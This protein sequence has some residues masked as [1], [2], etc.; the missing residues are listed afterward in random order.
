MHKQTPVTALMQQGWIIAALVIGLSGNLL[1]QPAEGVGVNLA[2][3]FGILGVASLS[4]LRQAGRALRSEA[5]GWIVGAVLLTTSAF[6]FRDAPTLHILAFL[7]AGAA[8]SFATRRGGNNWLREGGVIAPLE[9]IAGTVFHTARGPLPRC[10]GPLFRG[11]VIAVPILLLFGALLTEADPIFAA[12]L[13]KILETLVPA[14]LIDHLLLTAVLTW[15]AAGYLTGLVRGTAFLERLPPWARRLN[16]GAV[17]VN[18]VLGLVSVLFVGFLVVQTQTL[19]GG[20]EFVQKTPGLTY[21]IYAREGFFQLVVATALI[22]PLLTVGTWLVHGPSN[23]TSPQAPRPGQVRLFRHLASLHVVLLLLMAAS[24]MARVRIYQDAFGLTEMRLYAAVFLGW[25]ML[26]ALWFGVSMFRGRRR[27]FPGPLLISA[28]GILAGLIAVNPDAIVARDQLARGDRMDVAYVASLSADA[29]PSV[30]AAFSSLPAEH[31]GALRS[32]WLKRWGPEG[33][34][35][36][37]WHS[38]SWAEHRGRRALMTVWPDTP[39]TP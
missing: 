13:N 10:S 34:R 37:P 36:R 20:D 17:E 12:R 26:A 21:A 7:A 1:L 35:L 28:F 3:L 16:L 38:W 9:A 23:I 39:E 33:P 11:L 8:F 14:F 4:T 27:A 30:V 22:L 5:T 6:L 15:L 24:A 19:W 29:M 2:I 31:Q 25:L 18:L 32:A